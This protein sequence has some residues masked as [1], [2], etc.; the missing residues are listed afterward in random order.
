MIQVARERSSK[1]MVLMLI[2]DISKNISQELDCSSNSL[3]QK[4]KIKIPLSL[5]CKTPLRKKQGVKPSV[6]SSVHCSSCNSDRC[7]SLCKYPFN[8]SGQRILNDKSR[9]GVKAPTPPVHVRA[10]LLQQ[11]LT[12]MAMSSNPGISAP[13]AAGVGAAEQNLAIP[14][15]WF[16]SYM[17]KVWF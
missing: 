1:G 5:V 12:N 10:K 17:E 4:E 7:H 2:V 9:L 16:I 14:P 15:A 11:V 13:T 8:L 3:E 6:K